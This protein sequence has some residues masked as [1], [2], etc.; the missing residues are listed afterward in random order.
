MVGVRAAVALALVSAPG[1]GKNDPTVAGSIPTIPNVGAPAAPLIA[2]FTYEVV[3]VWPHDRAAF[4]QGLAFRQG[5][6]IE[7][8]GLNG[9]STLRDVELSTG[10]VLKQISLPREY[11]AEGATVLDGKV[12]Q[13]TWQNQKGFIYDAA[14]F[15]RLGEFS[16]AGEGW[17]LTTDGRS[18]ILSD[19]SHRI[20]LIDPAT[21]RVVRTIEVMAAGQPV[22]RLNELEF[23]RGEIFANVWQ[24]DRV[25]RIDAASGQVRGEID[26]SALLPPSDRRPDTDVLNGI[27]YDAASD[28][29]FVTGKNWPKLF[30]VRLESVP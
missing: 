1:C 4:T 24:T 8:T 19:G 10:R 27:A 9:R 6:L 26:F 28:R 23:I 12:Y 2:R 29:L 22:A 17:G 14:T 13:L 25:V 21:W 3:A 15:A 11:F 5:S 18:L 30:E 20:R 7:S 16:Y